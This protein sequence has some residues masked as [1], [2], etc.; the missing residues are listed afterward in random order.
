MKIT[1][2]KLFILCLVSVVVV[3][4]NDVEPAPQKEMRGVWLGN[5]NFIFEGENFPLCTRVII[6]PR[7]M[8]NG[9]G[10]IID[11]IS[12]FGTCKVCARTIRG[13]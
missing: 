10:R 12:A 11:W 1:I 6:Q 5:E 13:R 9:G 3:A 4:K 8:S 2:T 7:G